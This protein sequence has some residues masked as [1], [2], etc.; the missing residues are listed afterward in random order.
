MP[1]YKG[2]RQQ[3]VQPKGIDGCADIAVRA[4]DK[5]EIESAQVLTK[6]QLKQTKSILADVA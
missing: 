6:R 4:E 1:A 2:L 5:L 3:G